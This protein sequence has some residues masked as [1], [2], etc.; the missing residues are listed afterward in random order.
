MVLGV[1]LADELQ[2]AYEWHH[3]QSRKGSNLPYMGHLLAV[4]SIVIEAGASE[5]AA[6]AAPS[7]RR[8]RLSRDAA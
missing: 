7:G 1:C 2:A 8:N 3:H 6:I 4:T 5:A